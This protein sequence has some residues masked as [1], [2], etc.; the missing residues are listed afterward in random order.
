MT[1]S[2]SLSA[3]EVKVTEAGDLACENVIHVVLP[4]CEK[5][6]EDLSNEKK[7]LKKAIKGI[8]EIVIEKRFQTVCLPAL[9]TG[10]L[11]FPLNEWGKVYVSQL[12]KFISK[13]KSEMKGKEIILC[14]S[15]IK[16]KD[17]MIKVVEKIEEYLREEQQVEEKK[18]NRVDIWKN[19]CEKILEKSE[20]TNELCL[21]CYMT[22]DG[23]SA[24][25]ELDSES[26]TINYE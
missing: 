19:C 3:G 21:L 13:H 26:E 16:A 22:G 11:K 15:D 7:I 23:I 4:K 17:Q 2:D 8:L 10:V 14:N 6:Q 20:K 12:I 24:K 1:S 25:L 5:G 18:S 9:G